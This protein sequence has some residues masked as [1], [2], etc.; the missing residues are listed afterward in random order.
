MR[1]KDKRTHGRNRGKLQNWRC[2]KGHDAPSVC[3][4]GGGGGGGIKET[5]SYCF[6]WPP[7]PCRPPNPLLR[8][9]VI[10]CRRKTEEMICAPC[11]GWANICPQEAHEALF[12]VPAAFA[13]L[14]HQRGANMMREITDGWRNELPSLVSRKRRRAKEYSVESRTSQALHRRTEILY[15]HV[16]TSRVHEVQVLRDRNAKTESEPAQR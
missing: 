14:T 2:K 1:F 3:M 12:G 4:R 15:A 13:S 10:V 6:C 11:L 9:C 16:Q 5:P 7:F 8:S